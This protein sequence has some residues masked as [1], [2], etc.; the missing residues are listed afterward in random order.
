MSTLGLLAT[1]SS[2]PLST[3]WALSDLGEFRGMQEVFTRSAPQILKTLKDFSL[4]ESAVSSNRIEGVHVDGRRVGTVVFGQSP[5]RDRDEE[6]IRGYKHALDLIYGA[7]Q[8]LPISCETIKTLHRLT[9]GNIW[10]AGIWKDRDGEIIEKYP[11]GRER[12]RF[13]TVLATQTPAAMDELVSLYNDLLRVKV[14]P[15]LVLIAAF[16]LDFLCIHPF[17]DGNGRVSRLLLALQLVQSGYEV[18]RYLSLERLIETNKERYY[19]TLEISS[20]GWHESSHD[21]WPYINYLLFILKTAYKDFEERAQ[22]V[23]PVLGAKTQAVEEAIR[24]FT[25]HFTISEIQTNCPKVS[26]EL[27][28]KVL[29]QLKAQGAIEPISFGRKAAWNKKAESRYWELK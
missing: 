20:Q 2:L 29:K 15:P 9:R 14:V 23:K 3:T 7:P 19:E 21:P 26:L 24:S 17:R 16:N 1:L 10:D 8:S 4:V 6:E 12:I 28:R 25:G 11:D 18:G 13:H 5:I 27:I 22:R